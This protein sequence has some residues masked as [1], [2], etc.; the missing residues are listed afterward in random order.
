[1][2]AWDWEWQILLYPQQLQNSLHYGVELLSYYKCVWVCVNI[3]VSIL[4][5]IHTIMKSPTHVIF[6]MSMFQKIQI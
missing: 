5:D 6:K 2:S 1:M 3:F 4:N